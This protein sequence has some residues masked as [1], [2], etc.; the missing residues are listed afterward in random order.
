MASEQLDLPVSNRKGAAKAGPIARRI[1]A[2]DWTAIRES[3][4][5]SGCATTPA[6]LT[7]MQCEALIALY[8]DASRFRKR[9]EMAR[10]RFGVGEYKYFAE[11]LPPI[12]Q[13]MRDCFY[14]R[15]VPIANRWM[16]ML[17]LRQQFPPTSAAMRAMCR[18]HG[19]AQ[20]TPVMLRYDAGGYNCLHQ[21][22]YGEIA[23]PL[24]LTCVLSSLGG[25][26]T[27]GEFLLLENRP[28]SQSRG[29]AVVLQR[30]EAIIFATRFRPVRSTRGYYRVAMRH[31]VSTLR[32]GRRFSLGIIFHDAQR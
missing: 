20:P 30:G 4:D 17:R 3:L 6:I 19:Q 9:V 27:G 10:M 24:Q 12:V 1:D 25:D 32:R 15:L 14:P 7:A 31:G 16:K 22:L 26:Y 21:D 13:E 28:R 18:R 29:H 8:D 11:P 5:E 2:L 23:Y